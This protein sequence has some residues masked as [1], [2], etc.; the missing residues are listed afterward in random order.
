MLSA[1]FC[2]KKVQECQL[3]HLEPFLS[4]N[5]L[6]FIYQNNMHYQNDKCFSA[7]LAVVFTFYLSIR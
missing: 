3:R 7:I 2:T 6:Y 4:H 1:L 5:F